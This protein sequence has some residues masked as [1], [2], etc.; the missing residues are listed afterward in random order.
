M[1]VK[2]SVDKKTVVCGVHRNKF[3]ASR[4]KSETPKLIVERFFRL[5]QLSRFHFKR[6]HTR[7]LLLDDGKLWEK[8]K[9][10]LKFSEHSR[11]WSFVHV[12]CRLQSL[13][14]KIVLSITKERL[15]NST[16]TTFCFVVLLKGFA[17]SS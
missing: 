10:Q 14:I 4:P 16:V 9:K 3:P 5:I 2:I 17:N 6:S 15:N 11:S 8:K 1:S 12:A 13:D 7:L